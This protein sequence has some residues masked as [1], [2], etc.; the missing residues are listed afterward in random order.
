MSDGASYEKLF[1][2]FAISR[3]HPGFWSVSD[4]LHALHL[5]SDP[6]NYGLLD[7]NR[8]ENR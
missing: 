5:E 4:R 1:D 3:T 7:Y 6:V 2:N 8:L